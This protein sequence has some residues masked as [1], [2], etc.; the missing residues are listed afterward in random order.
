[1]AYAV[2]TRASNLQ[3]VAFDPSTE[4][5]EGKPI[6]ITEGSNVAAHSDVSPDGEW[7]AFAESLDVAVIRTDG[8]GLRKLT[9]DPYRDFNPDW[10]PDGSQIGFYSNRS[11]K[12]DLWTIKPDGSGLRQITEATEGRGFG[13]F[14]WSPDGSRMAYASFEGGSYIF[15]LDRPWKEQTPQALP[16]FSDQEGSNFDSWSPD[17]KW[18][19]G[20]VESSPGAATGIVIYNIESQ[21]YQQI[22]DFGWDPAWLSDSRRLLFTE[23][24]GSRILLVDRHSAG[25]R[26]L[27]TIS[28]DEVGHVGT[29][30]D[31]RWIYFTRYVNET[32]IW[33]LTLN[34]EH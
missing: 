16:P 25:A 26:E 19:A 2:W 8:T 29:S 34:E 31:D 13:D 22:T 15:G 23:P 9:D 20:Y 5:V 12:Y 3:K 30:P 11:G 10:S 32:D 18:L 14:S 17:G 24:R 4:C 6:W 21:Q 27:L 1:M 28:P 33:M 7:L